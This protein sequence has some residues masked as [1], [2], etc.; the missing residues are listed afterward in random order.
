MN[1]FP[2]AS[3][4]ITSYNYERFVREAIE[5]AL[6]QTYR[7]VE[8]IVVDDGSTDKSPALAAGYRDR[9]ITVLKENGGQ[10]SASAQRMNW[11]SARSRIA[12]TCMTC[13]RRSF[14]CWGWTIAN[15]RSGSRGETSA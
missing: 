9:V 7:R 15:S 11:A 6:A 8:V 12:S 1:E 5:S 4:V 2:L 10:A 13:R 14:T 3:I